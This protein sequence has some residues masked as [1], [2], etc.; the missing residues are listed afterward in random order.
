MGKIQDRMKFHLFS[1]SVLATTIGTICV[2]SPFSTSKTDSYTIHE[3][4][5]TTASNRWEKI[6]RVQP[7]STLDV[8]ISLKHNNIDKAHGFMNDV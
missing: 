3:K 4:R 5:E 6:G 7:E 2:A 8:Q 1:L